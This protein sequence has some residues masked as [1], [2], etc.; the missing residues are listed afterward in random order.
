M[1]Q[2]IIEYKNI[3]AALEELIDNSPYKKGFIIKEVGFSS[4]TF[5]RKLKNLS[6]TPDEVL[7]IVKII[8]PNEAF[9][10]ELLA[11]I[12][13]GRA[14]IKNGNTMT[15]EDVRTAMRLKIESYQ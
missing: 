3:L 5:Y 8:K 13:Q 6:F 2:E 4:P 12:E 14:D 7:S 1:I 15:S 11:E 9:K 10:H